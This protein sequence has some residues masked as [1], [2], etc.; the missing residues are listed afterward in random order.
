[1]PVIEALNC[2]IETAKDFLGIKMQ[3]ISVSSIGVLRIKQ[4]LIRFS[5]RDLLSTPTRRSNEKPLLAFH[6]R[7]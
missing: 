2:D 4:I 7:L 5:I 6:R 3:I 1:M